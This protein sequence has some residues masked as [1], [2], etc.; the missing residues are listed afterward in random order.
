MISSRMIEYVKIYSKAI[1]DESGING[2]RLN[3]ISYDDSFSPPKTVEQ[4]RK[5]GATASMRVTESRFEATDP[6]IVSQIDALKNTGADILIAGCC[7][8]A[9]AQ[10][11]FKV[12]ELGWKPTLF[13][14]SIISRHETKTVI[15][16]YSALGRAAVAK[17]RFDF[18]VGG[19]YPDLSNFKTFA[20]V[21]QTL[22]TGVAA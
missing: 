3:F 20:S 5:P 12:A 1:N 15:T 17:P 6:T 2:R 7:K 8:T 16:P 9:G 11:I 21:S 13:H 14:N 4:A 18:T 19:K 10:A 22:D